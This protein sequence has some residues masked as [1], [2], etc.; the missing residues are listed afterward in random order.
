M[1]RFAMRLALRASGWFA[2][3]LFDLACALE[4]MDSPKE[5]ATLPVEGPSVPI[6]A[7]LV[8][9]S[10]RTPHGYACS[11]CGKTTTIGSCRCGLS[12]DALS[13]WSRAS[14]GDC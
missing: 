10:I 4:A 9:Q 1:K 2:E 6:V 12:D 5:Q 11:T 13:R 8:P 14:A 7:R 3:K